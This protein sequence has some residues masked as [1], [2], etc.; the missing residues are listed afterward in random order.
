M[1]KRKKLRHVKI[2][3]EELVSTTIGYVENKKTNPLFLI[4][5]FGIFLAF[6]Y[7]VP[8]INEYVETKRGNTV[9]RNNTNNLVKKVFNQNDKGKEFAYKD[10][11]TITIKEVSIE[12]FKLNN[13]KFVFK[14]KNNSNENIDFGKNSYYLYLK[15]SEGI[16]NDRISLLNMVIMANSEKS[17]TFD[18]NSTNINTLFVDEL[19][20]EYLEDV[21]LTDNLLTCY[22]ENEAYTYEF[23]DLK[24]INETYSYQTNSASEIIINKYQKLF[25]K[26]S[27]INGI[28]ASYHVSEA[29]DLY[30]SLKVYLDVVDL[31]QLNDNNFFIKGEN[32]KTINFEMEQQGFKCS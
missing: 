31:T 7:Y 27:K 15:D 16:I 14:I 10:S 3:D 12:D 8:E 6:L 4:V 18:I 28:E 17:L 30:Y 22:L 1:A 29:S 32:S 11:P 9:Y 21:V 5:L 20:D 23:L 24:L 25:D 19:K 26:N 13:D 2:V